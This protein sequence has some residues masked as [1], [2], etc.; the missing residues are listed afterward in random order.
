MKKTEHRTSRNKVGNLNVHPFLGPLAL[1][2]QQS[3]SLENAPSTNQIDGKISGTEAQD[4][5]D[6][7]ELARLYI[8]VRK[9]ESDSN[10]IDFELA[11][12][13][14]ILWIHRRH[15]INNNPALWI[16]IAESA[17]IGAAYALAFVL[18][19]SLIQ[20]KDGI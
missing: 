6:G 11:K 10:A 13:R 8:P 19:A 3:L 2:G 14:P 20:K 18:L 12:K 17:L 4:Y 15:T 5:T 16:E 7:K 9:A 1:Q